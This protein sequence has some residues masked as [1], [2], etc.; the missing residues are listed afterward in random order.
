MVL[1]F[2]GVLKKYAVE[3]K[4]PDARNQGIKIKL[5]SDSASNKEDDSSGET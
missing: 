5:A 2:E 4:N 1:L 3:A